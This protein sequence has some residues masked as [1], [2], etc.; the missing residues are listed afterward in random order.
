[1]DTEKEEPVFG[2]ENLDNLSL[3]A[4]NP[5]LI[6]IVFGPVG[7]G[8]STLGHHFIFKGANDGNNVCLI[9][10]DPPS[11]LATR[12]M[13]FKGYDPSWIKDGYISIFKLTNLMFHV[14]IDIERPGKGDLRHLMNL[15]SQMV[16]SMDLKRIVID[17]ARPLLDWIRRDDPEA[18]EVLRT[19]LVR[20]GASA[21]FIYDTGLVSNVITEIPSPHM[22]DIVVRCDRE[23]E[24]NN[25]MN[26]LSIERW[27]DS[28]HSRL[29]YVLDISP[30]GL[31]LVPRLEY[32]EG[33]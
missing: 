23:M 22:F 5:G 32:G 17:P 3:G 19:T 24:R 30:E 7:V 9:T 8:K 1:V 14:G 13:R 16:D 28:V 20:K 27:K 10:T 18:L 2:I 15:L 31:V 11:L 12:F 29:K 21:L 25:G 26:I 4:M 33:S 6:G